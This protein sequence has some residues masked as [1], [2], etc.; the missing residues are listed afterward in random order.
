MDNFQIA[1]LFE[2][3]AGL[4]ELREEPG[5]TVRAYRLAALTIKDL[6]EDVEQ[7]VREERDLREIPGIGKAIS[8]KIRELVDT[9]SL[10]YYEK[11]RAEFPPGIL[12][13]MHVRG[14]GAKTTLRAW[15]ELGVTSVDDLEHAIHEGKMAALPRM[16]K[17]AADNILREIQLARSTKH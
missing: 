10:R 12:E 17:K 3:I 8:D 13:L 1:E 4:L 9:G 14:M 16:G 7:M 5:F 11:L 6:P 15:K 2:N